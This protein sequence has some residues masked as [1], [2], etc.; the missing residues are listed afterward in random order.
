MHKNKKASHIVENLQILN[1]LKEDD[2][3]NNHDNLLEL[4]FMVLFTKE[5]KTSFWQLTVTDCLEEDMNTNG[6]TGTT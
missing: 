6:A 4:L 1:N 3:K 5:E 2:H